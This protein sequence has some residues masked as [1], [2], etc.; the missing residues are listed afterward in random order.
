MEVLDNG[1]HTSHVSLPEMLALF[2]KCVHLLEISYST[3]KIRILCGLG[4]DFFT[5]NICKGLLGIFCGFKLFG[6]AIV[7]LEEEKTLELIK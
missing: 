7:L 2:Q 6:N 1:L 5:H 3:T 4:P